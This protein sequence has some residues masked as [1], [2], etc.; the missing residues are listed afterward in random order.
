MFF[1]F[2]SNFLEQKRNQSDFTCSQSVCS[3]LFHFPF[4]E[5]IF[6]ARRLFPFPFIFG[7]RNDYVDRKYSSIQDTFR[8][9][10][11]HTKRSKSHFI[12]ICAL[13]IRIK[14]NEA[15]SSIYVHNLPVQRFLYSKII[16]F[17]T[18]N[19][20]SILTTHIYSIVFPF[21]YLL[22]CSDLIDFGGMYLLTHLAEQ[23]GFYSIFSCQ[24]FLSAGT[25][26][27]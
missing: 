11:M 18:R 23:V 17:N 13:K 5:S 10:T 2:I 7:S 3:W 6:Y 8:W 20:R 1:I 14:V 22:S 4:R 24:L 19:Y 21:I 27:N 15:S 16:C 26:L 25:S 12:C 9:T